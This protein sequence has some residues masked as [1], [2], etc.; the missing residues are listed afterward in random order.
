MKIERPHFE[1]T[2]VF[3]DGTEES[4]EIIPVGC[5]PWDTQME[6]R[7][8]LGI[9]LGVASL[10]L[11]LDGKATAHT[12]GSRLLS[13]AIV[14]ESTSVGV[15]SE[16]LKA[17]AEGISSLVVGESTL[18]SAAA[19]NIKIW[20]LPEGKLLTT[21]ES[22]LDTKLA[23]SPNG[24]ILVS[25]GAGSRLRLRSL[26]SGK[27]LSL[28]DG[29]ANT[30]LLIDSNNQ[31]ISGSSGGAIEIWSLPKGESLRTLHGH[32]ASVAALAISP[33]AKLLVSA[34]GDE[35]MKL[36]SLIDGKLLGN[37][38]GP[39]GDVRTLVFS[40]DGNIVVSGSTDKKIKFWS[41]A[42]RKVLTT[43]SG[44]RNSIN[45]LLFTPDG[46]TLISC[47]NDLSIKLW[48]FPDGKHIATLK[49]HE[50]QP[51]D[52]ALSKDGKILGS[53]DT[54]GVIILWHL[55][56]RSF[57]SFLFDPKVNQKDAIAF[58][59]YDSITGNTL[60]YTLPCGSPIPQGA[61]CTC[62]CV[63][64]TY[65]PPTPTPPSTWP[66]GGGGIPYCMCNK[67]CTC[68][69]VPSDRNVKMD[70][71]TTEPMTILARLA[72]L[73]I[74]SWRYNWDN[75]SVRHIG[76]MA[77][78]FA[79]LFGVGEDDKHIHPVDAQ[80]VA[81]ASI[82]ALYRLLKEELARTECFQTQ[83]R[84]QQEMSDIFKRRLDALESRKGDV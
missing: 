66:R 27:F 33:D 57:L 39:G 67:V 68:I 38:V 54:S 64:G 65:S 1:L 74:Q 79:S 61:V 13:T 31:L 71:E 16:K 49:G 25:G 62:N 19:D 41:L 45:K 73:P 12:E 30:A 7:G 20:S 50:S 23:V 84:Q 36:W 72:D 6:R 58:N 77:Q 18:I 40:A 15:P 35:T 3:S 28:L 32:L 8:F 48:S 46:K 5:I 37:F 56:K 76:P 80:G 69:P 44:H 24:K 34:S 10:L 4:P 22:N 47:A 55:E 9:G 42:N 26:P 83:L 52:L 11:L 14:N 60:T 17:H 51:I 63:A 2:R 59:A 53:G 78:D 21:L 75:A 81:L 43:L 82:Q 70:F 29:E